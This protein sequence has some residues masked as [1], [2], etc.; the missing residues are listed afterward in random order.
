MQFLLYKKAKRLAKARPESHA[1]EQSAVLLRLFLLRET[2]P[3][4]ARLEVPHSHCWN[5][6]VSIGNDDDDDDDD[7]CYYYGC[8]PRVWDLLLLDAAT[9]RRRCRQRNPP[10]SWLVES[11]RVTVCS[12][13]VWSAGEDRLLNRRGASLQ[14]EAILSMDCG[15]NFQIIIQCK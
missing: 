7:C 15:V 10:V 8:P 11:M 14:Y 3:R 9:H 13:Q 1:L 2:D 12:V 6:W 5:L 4:I